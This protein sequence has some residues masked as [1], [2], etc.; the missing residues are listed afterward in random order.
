[1]DTIISCTWS[2]QSHLDRESRTQSNN[3]GRLLQDQGL[4][5][6]PT[7][8]GIVPLLLM[9]EKHFLSFVWIQ[10][11]LVFGPIILIWIERV[12]LNPTMQGLL[13]HDQG[14]ALGPTNHGII[15]L[16]LVI[17]RL[18]HTCMDTIMSWT[19]SNQSNSD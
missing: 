14:L 2:N 11:C 19:W 17:K 5:L 12:G 4:A 16:A 15:L 6:G 7:N 1:M 9:V 3:G 18:P 10:L 13:L 8:H